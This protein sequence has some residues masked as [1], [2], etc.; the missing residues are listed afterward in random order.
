[1]DENGNSRVPITIQDY[2][3]KKSR[4]EI[5]DGVQI[6][7]I[8]IAVLSIIM[9]VYVVGPI[10]FIVLQINS[11]WV[12]FFWLLSIQLFAIIGLIST[13]HLLIIDFVRFLT[14]RAVDGQIVSVSK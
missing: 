4:K 11:D 2:A 9:D 5:I 3:H 14:K 1:M 10:L 6:K 13:V 12:G 7:M 8:G